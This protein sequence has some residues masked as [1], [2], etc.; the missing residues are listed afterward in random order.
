MPAVT[1]KTKTTPPRNWF[2]MLP[3]PEMIQTSSPNL[4]RRARAFLEGVVDILDGFFPKDA[5][6]FM[7]KSMILLAAQI[8]D[9]FDFAFEQR[10]P[11]MFEGQ[12]VAGCLVEAI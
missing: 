2:L 3:S 6:I 8:T 10:G 4:R 12:R 5:I 1:A 9:D 7:I 11:Y